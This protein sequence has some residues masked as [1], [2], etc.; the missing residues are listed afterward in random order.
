MRKFEVYHPR[1]QNA[2]KPATR[3][4]AGLLADDIRQGKRDRLRRRFASENICQKWRH[5]EVAKLGFSCIRTKDEELLQQYA[6]SLMVDP[7]DTIENELKDVYILEEFPPLG[8]YKNRGG[9]V[10]GLL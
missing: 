9:M 3:Q 4:H 2:V 7:L 8:R 10:M 6:V 1:V 5:A